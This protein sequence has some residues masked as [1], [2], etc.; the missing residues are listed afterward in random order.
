M[1]PY[2]V[3]DY[4]YHL[5]SKDDGWFLQPVIGGNPIGG[6]LFSTTDGKNR[7][8]VRQTAE[9]IGEAWLHSL[10]ER[11]HS[12]LPWKDDSGIYMFG[13]DDNILVGKLP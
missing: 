8:I 2:R 4:S 7:E 11:P 12:Y 1:N 9:A 5:V 6:Y 3:E 10:R 13:P